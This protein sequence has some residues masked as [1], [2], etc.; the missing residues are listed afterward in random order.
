MKPRLPRQA[1]TVVSHFTVGDDIT[2]KDTFDFKTV[3]F[4][5]YN[6]IYRGKYG[7]VSKI[8]EHAR[9]KETCIT[10]KLDEYESPTINVPSKSLVHGF[11]EMD[12][13]SDS[14][15]SGGDLYVSEQKM[16]YVRQ[17]K[18]KP[19]SKWGWGSMFGKSQA[20]EARPDLVSKYNKASTES[21]PPPKATSNAKDSYG[22]ARRRVMKEI[23]SS[24]TMWKEGK[25][26]QK[27][28]NVLYL[29]IH[30]DFAETSKIHKL[31]GLI[32]AP[33]G[34]FY[35][36]INFKINIELNSYPFK[37]PK[38][39]FETPIYHPNIPYPNKPY[40]LG[41]TREKWSPALNIGSVLQGTANLLKDIFRQREYALNMDAHLLYTTNQTT[42]F[43]AKARQ[44]SGEDARHLW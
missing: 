11:V 40:H 3:G 2:I 9:T 30:P 17:K 28:P 25:W 10:V 36:E 8:Y 13:D 20:T 29:R 4:E 35:E 39:S 31:Q 26:K 5:R 22:N 41:I 21:R 42:K 32:S 14:S 6:R 33:R 43:K 16:S 1:S 34:S 44:F 24:T 7:S 12:V 19:K 38:V 23:K 37:P 18:V 15:S 27:Y